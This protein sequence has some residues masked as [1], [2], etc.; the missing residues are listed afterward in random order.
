MT[1][2]RLRVLVFSTFPVAA[3]A[4]GSPA[5]HAV[6]STGQSMTPPGDDGSPP[7]VDSTGVG[8]SSEGSADTGTGPSEECELPELTE[9]GSWMF[10]ASGGTNFADLSCAVD[11]IADIAHTFTAALPGT[12]SFRVEPEDSGLPRLAIFEGACPAG[13]ELVCEDGL[14]Q[15]SA[16][17]SVFLEQ[18]QTITVV[19]EASSSGSERPFTLVFEANTLSGDCPDETLEGPFPIEVVGSTARSENTAFASCGGVLSPDDQY[20]FVAPG[21]GTYVFDTT[22][23]T[24]DTVLYVLDECGGNEL[25]CSDAVEWSGHGTEVRV[26]LDEGE[27]VIVGVDG[28]EPEGGTYALSVQRI[29]CPNVILDS[30]PEVSYAGSNAGQPNG[31][32]GSCGGSSGPETTF[33]YTAPAAGWYEFDSRGSANPT[34][35]YIANECGG[36]E[37]ACTF[38]ERLQVELEEG[39]TII[40]TVDS[41]GRN[42]SEIAL[43]V[44]YLQCP[45][46]E[47]GTDVPASF[48]GSFAGATN[49]SEG[50]CGGS[51]STERVHH[52]V[53]PQDGVYSIVA[54]PTGGSSAVTYVLDGAECGAANAELMCRPSGSG[55]VDL[56]AGQSVLVVVEGQSGGYTLEIDRTEC[57]NAVVELGEDC[58]PPA[59]T[60]SCF[61]A[62]AGG[63]PTTVECNEDCTF[64]VTECGGQCNDGTLDLGESCDLGEL[65][66]ARCTDFGF[67]G[68]AL[69][70]SEC[71]FDLSEC[72][73]DVVVYCS[74]PDEGESVLD[75]H[76]IIVP[77]MGTI[78]DVDVWVDMDY[79]SL[80]DLGLELTANSLGVQSVLFSDACNGSDIQA[81]FNDEGDFHVGAGC[82]PPTWLEGNMIPAESLS[83]FD[84]GEA[85]GLWTLSAADASP[86]TGSLNAWCLT[87]TF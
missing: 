23:S 53:A 66:G 67:V 62:G 73:N 87:F 34:R 44:D 38:H 6:A 47:L 76:T 50:S 52:F 75:E 35:L 2:S 40:I 48:T 5:T 28:Q 27:S 14:G 3:C 84:G 18:G 24:F 63:G 41:A 10:D 70:C 51:S 82:A 17:A 16:S 78:A 30:Q 7:P 36:P 43:E 37:L 59:D 61:S 22:G 56:V 45:D 55:L 26:P 85:F 8:E 31:S 83:A 79:D 60:A 25:A 13:A 46:Y 1:A 68:G 33:S 58:E 15:P 19:A 42:G 64:D 32:E 72:S 74:E 49:E 81:T 12:Y 29:F 39:Q 69:G 11:D 4:D 9:P 21:Q 20:S 71:S 77:E 65:S 54:S 86:G 80:G 57:G